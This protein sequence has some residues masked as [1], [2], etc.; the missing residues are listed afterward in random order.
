MIKFF[1]IGEVVKSCLAVGGM[2]EAAKG[3]WRLVMQLG[4]GC[5]F[6]YA[7]GMKLFVSGLDEFV[8]EIGNYQLVSA[9]L[10]AVIA[11]SLPWLEVLVGLFL[12][13]NFQIRA[14]SLWALLMTLVFL[15]GIS[16]G[17][18]RGIDLHCG[19]FGKSLEAVNYPR[20]IS[21]LLLQLAACIGVYLWRDCSFIK[22]K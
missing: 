6:V 16:S 2:S 17:W 14:A 19:C 11:Y 10:D 3:T 21:A 20:K 8:K 5:L 18:W 7:G 12:L 4:L 22:K 13:V 1:L 15:F 9:P